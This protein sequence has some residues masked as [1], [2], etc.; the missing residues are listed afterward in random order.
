MIVILMEHEFIL[1]SGQQAHYEGCKE[2]L[3]KRASAMFSK[4]VSFY[5]LIVKEDLPIQL[6]NRHC[7]NCKEYLFSLVWKDRCR[8]RM[9]PVQAAG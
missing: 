6:R 4:C 5:M 7:V 3:H 8:K 9:I 1:D 2:V